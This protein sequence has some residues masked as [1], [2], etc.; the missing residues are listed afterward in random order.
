MAI[1]S[2]TKCLTHISGHQARNKHFYRVQMGWFNSSTSKL[3]S[4]SLCL[5]ISLFFLRH[6][7]FGIGLFCFI[8]SPFET[9][10][11]FPFVFRFAWNVLLYIFMCRFTQ[12][13]NTRCESPSRRWAFHKNDVRVI[14]R[15]HLQ[16]NTS[17]KWKRLESISLI[18]TW[19]RIGSIRSFKYSTQC[20]PDNADIGIRATHTRFRLI[21]SHLRM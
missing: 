5:R 6:V 13:R 18:R 19:D 17:I 1:A 9:E 2:N 21:A 4:L 12:R 7:C 20:A 10:I 16:L 15:R 8:F 14:N 3:L 11:H